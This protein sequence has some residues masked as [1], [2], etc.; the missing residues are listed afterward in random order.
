MRR[1]PA[2]QS[3]F[4]I[5]YHTCGKDTTATEKKS[6][7]VTFVIAVLYPVVRFHGLLTCRDKNAPSR[8]GRG[9]GCLLEVRFPDVVEHEVHADDI[10][11]NSHDGITEKGKLLQRVHVMT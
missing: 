1:L 3:P 10:S 6:R 9:G 11:R 7:V 2:A 4:C 5:V 8:M